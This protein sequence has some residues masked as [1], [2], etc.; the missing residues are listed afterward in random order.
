VLEKQR[1]FIVGAGAMGEAMIKGLLS[2]HLVTPEQITVTNRQ[3]PERLVALQQTYG[4]QVSRDI[5]REIAEADIVLLA[6]KPSDLVPAFRHLVP[7][8]TAH[9]LVISLAAGITTANLEACLEL[10]IPLIRAMPNASCAVLASATAICPGQWARSQHLQI[11]SFIFAAIGTAVVV[12]ESLMD[13]VTGLSGSGPAY[14]YYVIEALLQGGISCGISRETSW[15]LL[16]QTMLGAA[17]MLKESGKEPS[18]LRRQ[19]TSPNGT[20]MAGI[21]VLDQANVQQLIVQAVEQATARATEMGKI[22]QNKVL[23][24]QKAKIGNRQ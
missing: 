8:L 17:T 19:V 23:E 3:R 4:I 18:E 15:A 21:A 5:L 22:A 13:A 1:I 14:F 10:P 9:H 16:L 6:T 2:A 7:A 12:D 24:E 20:T 11:A